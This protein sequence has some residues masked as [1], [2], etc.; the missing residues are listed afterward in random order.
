M[1]KAAPHHRFVIFYRN[2][3]DTY[4]NAVRPKSKAA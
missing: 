1:A 3:M 4:T 2:M